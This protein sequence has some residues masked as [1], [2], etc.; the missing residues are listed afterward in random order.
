MSISKE[1]M[2]AVNN[3]DIV[4]AKIILKNNMLLDPSFALYDET[5]AYVKNALGDFSDEHDG[6]EF[7][8]D[9]DKWDKD[10]LAALMVDLM[11]NFSKER[12][13]HIRK[14]CAKIYKKTCSIHTTKTESAYT[15]SNDDRCIHN[16]N[17]GR[18]SNKSVGIG[19]AIGGAAVA[20]VGLAVSKPIIFG[21]GV[22]AA[23]AG[24]VVIVTDK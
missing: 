1:L 21:V 12:I 14:V 15:H 13:E 17:S 9:V 18:I 23:I 22:V 8:S 16:S 24:G 11:L 3:N 2:D 20:A 4:M 5:S 10:Y 19:L 6:E 7:E